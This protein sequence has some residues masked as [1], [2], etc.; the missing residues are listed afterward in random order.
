MPWLLVWP[1][2]QQQWYSLHVQYGLASSFQVNFK[3]LQC[4]SIQDWCEI[5]MSFYVLFE[6]F[7]MTRS[8]ILKI[9]NLLFICVITVRQMLYA[10]Y[11]SC[12]KVCIDSQKYSIEFELWWKI[13]QWNGLLALNLNSLWSR[14]DKWRHRSRWTFAQAMACCLTAPSHYLN[15]CW[16]KNISI[17]S[18]PVWFQWRYARY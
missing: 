18:I 6:K 8:R 11:V 13:F 4:C 10:A 16:L 15:Q 2:H 1:G 5:Q 3:N 9:A 7:S 14:D 12:A 17:H